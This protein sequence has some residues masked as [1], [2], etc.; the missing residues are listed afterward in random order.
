M[1]PNTSKNEALIARARE[2]ANVPWC[3]EYE[4]MISGML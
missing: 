4:Q 3:E 1:K 2:A